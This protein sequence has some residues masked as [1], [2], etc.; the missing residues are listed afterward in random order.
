MNLNKEINM[1]RIPGWAIGLVIA[2]FPMMMVLMASIIGSML[3]CTVHEGFSN[4]CLV[5]DYDIGG[6]LHAFFGFGWLTFITIPIGVFVGLFWLI[7]DVNKH[8]K[9]KKQKTDTNYDIP[10]T[11]TSLKTKALDTKAKQ[12]VKIICIIIVVYYLAIGLF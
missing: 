2:F 10:I 4:P 9:S 11:Q 3:N 12:I 7:R 1:P 6:T 8:I 5:L